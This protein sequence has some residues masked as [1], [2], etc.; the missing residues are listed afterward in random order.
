[1][2]DIDLVVTDL[3][4]TLWELPESTPEVTVRAVDTLAERGVPLLVATGRRRASTQRPLA[5]LGLTP[6]AVMLN[7]A[8]GVDLASGDRFHLGGFSSQQAATVLASF[9]DAEL[10]PV[11]YVDTDDGAVRV[12]SSPSTHPDHLASFGADVFTDDL[13]RVCADEHVLGFSVLGIDA[14]L[15]IGLGEALDGVAAPHVA[16]DRGYGNHAIT[17]APLGD[18]KWDGIEAFCASEGLDAQRVLV[19]GDGPNDIEMLERAAVA[20]VP[21]DGHAGALAQ[22]DHVCARAADGGWAELLDLV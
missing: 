5:Q 6:P 1:M 13:H 7:G 9:L 17:V 2:T 21:A 8:L 20:V 15:A 19:I 4:G 14:Q 12:S 3:D 10:H 11:V 22:A 16:P 18:S